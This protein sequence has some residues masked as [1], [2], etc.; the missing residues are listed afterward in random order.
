M[1]IMPLGDSIT[2]G[3]GSPGGYRTPLAQDL[4]AQG[5]NFHFVGS[6]TL[7]DT[8]YLDQLGDQGQEGHPGTTIGAIQSGISAWMQASGATPNIILLMI[9]TNDIWQ[10]NGPATA[11]ARLA[12]LLNELYQLDPSA[13]V[14][15]STLIPINYNS[16]NP[17]YPGITAAT[18]QA[19][20][21][22]NAALPGSRRPAGCSRA[23]NHS[24]R[25]A[26]GS[27]PF[28]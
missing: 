1:T 3:V 27:R 28:N 22:Y 17:Q 4:T 5:I 11:P 16:P 8:A 20:Q 19:A 21:T 15:L 7:N 9:G 25:C 24:C 26:P 10:N 6:V 2:Y 23:K 12:S 18:E 14:I 13:T